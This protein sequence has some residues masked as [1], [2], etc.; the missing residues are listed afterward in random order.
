MPGSGQICIPRSALPVNGQLTYVP[1]KF[2]DDEVAAHARTAGVIA[3]LIPKYIPSFGDI[4]PPNPVV[5]WVRP[6]DLATRD[7]VN[8]VLALAQEHQPE[9][10]RQIVTESVRRREIGRAGSP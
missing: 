7:G 2:F 6:G 3:D 8:R 1:R 9:L 4:G 5:G 10:F